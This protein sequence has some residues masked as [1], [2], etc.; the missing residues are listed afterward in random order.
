MRKHLAAAA[1]ILTC[2]LALS[3]CNDGSTAAPAATPPAPT[4]S[5][6]A[7]ATPDK[8]D[9]APVDV[10]VRLVLLIDGQG[11]ALDIKPPRSGLVNNGTPKPSATGDP[12]DSANPADPSDPADS[13]DPS[14]TDKPDTDTSPSDKPDK[15]DSSSELKPIADLKLGEPTEYLPMKS[16]STMSIG[17]APLLDFPATGAGERQTIAIGTNAAGKLEATGFIEK[18]GKVTGEF[19][20]SRLLDSQAPKDDKATVFGSGIGL[21]T[22][23]DHKSMT[24][25]VPGKGCLGDK[26]VTDKNHVAYPAD[27][28]DIEL[29]WFADADCKTAAGD[30]TN[31]TLK[32]GQQAYAFAWSTSAEPKLIFIP[33]DKTS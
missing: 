32:A 13:T 31:V 16:G 21:G 10:Q 7:K 18:D 1:G 3:A 24:L 33:I 12:T 17:G 4:G 9:T 8:K 11:G 6:S 28:G 2:A 5:A 29:G 25:G 30:T 14:D 27:P 26:A 23:K 20:T 15:P 22:S 19:G